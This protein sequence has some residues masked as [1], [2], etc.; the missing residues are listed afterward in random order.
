MNDY[1]IFHYI[2]FSIFS[3]EKKGNVSS[4]YNRIENI[5]IKRSK[6]NNEISISISYLTAQK[7]FISYFF[8]KFD[9]FQ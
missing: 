2:K 8:K 3:R 7:F 1:L 4:E 6:L 9:K 5:F